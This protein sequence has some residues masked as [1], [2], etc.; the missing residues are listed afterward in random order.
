MA[1]SRASP[2]QAGPTVGVLSL[3]AGDGV[4]PRPRGS[5]QNP[6]G[7]LH[8][9]LGG[10]P[11]SKVRGRGPEAWAPG[12][13]AWVWEALRGRAAARLRAG[14]GGLGPQ[15]SSRRRERSPPRSLPGTRNV[16]CAC[17]LATSPRRRRRPARQRP[18]AFR[19]PRQGARL[20][21][22]GPAPPSA[23][24][25]AGASRSLGD[26]ATGTGGHVPAEPRAAGALSRPREGVCVQT[27]A[28]PLVPAPVRLPFSAKLRTGTE[29]R[30][31]AGS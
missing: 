23:S 16:H 2:R 4:S 21:G 26:G 7:T 9:G 10:Q 31:G 19:V 5:A 17:S 24:L 6:S 20:R 30:P 1:S 25:P 11:G 8:L 22:P 29:G 28:R 18:P 12:R 3:R 13:R 14:A 15:A 27:W